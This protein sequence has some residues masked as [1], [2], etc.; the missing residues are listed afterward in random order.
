ME[1]KD[2][3]GA[4]IGGNNGHVRITDTAHPDKPTLLIVKDSFSHAMI[5]YL[6]QHFNLEILDLRYWRGS[7]NA[8]ADECDA[9]QVL[10]LLGLDSLASAPTLELL[11][12]GL[13]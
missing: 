7:V 13:K 3:Y 10:I 6:A 1:G 5:P 2:K 9:E 12:Y 4:L 8:L 11:K